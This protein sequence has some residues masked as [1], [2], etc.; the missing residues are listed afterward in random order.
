MSQRSIAGLIL[1][2]VLLAVAAC[3]TPSPKVTPTEETRAYIVPPF[4]PGLMATDFALETPNGD[5]LSLRDYQGQVVLINFWTTWCPSCKSEMYA[6]EKYYT[7]HRAEGFVVLAVNHKES[8]ETVAAFVEEESLSFPVVLDTQGSVAS[9][10][11]VTGIPVSFYVGRDGELLGHWPGALL[12]TML[13]Q[14]LTPI[15]KSE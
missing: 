9:A 6:L 12:H 15:L 3:A 4:K 1:G 5:T 11:N 13:E 2:L 10:Y 14:T 7:E 8:A